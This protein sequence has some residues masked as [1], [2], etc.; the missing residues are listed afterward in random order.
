MRNFLSGENYYSPENSSSEIRQL[1]TVDAASG[2]V[3]TATRPFGV[4]VVTSLLL[5]DLE[6]EKRKKEKKTRTTNPVYNF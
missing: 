2:G 3:S 4:P 5:F 1:G 6:K